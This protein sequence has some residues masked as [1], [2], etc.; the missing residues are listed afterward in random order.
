MSRSLTLLATQAA[1]PPI[2]YQRLRHGNAAQR[3]RGVIYR[4]LVGRDGWPLVFRPPGDAVPAL[5]PVMR[6]PSTVRII[7]ELAQKCPCPEVVDAIRA[8]L[9]R[10]QGHEDYAAFVAAS[11]VGA[12]GEPLLAL[13]RQRRDNAD[14]SSAHS[15][16]LDQAIAAI[17]AAVKAKLQPV[18]STSK[19]Q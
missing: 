17:E 3:L 15:E 13:L 14:V 19:P 9:E 5:A 10:G 7:I 8:I 1:D 16:Q 12:Y 2:D 4:L 11:H 18:F 6:R